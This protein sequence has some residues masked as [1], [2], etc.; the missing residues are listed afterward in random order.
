MASRQYGPQTSATQREQ[1][2]ET[3]LYTVTLNYKW[4]PAET[5]LID[6]NASIYWTQLEQRNAPRS[7]GHDPEDFGLPAD[8]LPGSG[9]RE[10]RTMLAAI[11]AMAAGCTISRPSL[12]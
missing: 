6:L 3:D 7:M 12:H 5:G 4:Q 9:R 10:C 2:T 11:I 1:M 8:F